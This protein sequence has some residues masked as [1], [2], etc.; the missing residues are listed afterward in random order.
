MPLR[1]HQRFEELL[2]ATAKKHP[3]TADL[4]MFLGESFLKCVE[5]FL[6]EANSFDNIH[7]SPEQQ[8]IK[9]LV[10]EFNAEPIRDR[11]VHFDLEKLT[12]A[13]SEEKPEA[14]PTDTVRQADQVVRKAACTVMSFFPSF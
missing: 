4:E 10:K 11:F 3:K 14:E 7:F 1:K 13:I 12:F 9:N 5:D 6:K 2:L 8:F